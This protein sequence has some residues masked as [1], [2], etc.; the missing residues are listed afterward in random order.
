MEEYIKN[1]FDK[2][3][4]YEMA[5]N[6][7]ISYNKVDWLC[8]KLGLKHYKSVKYTDSEIEFIKNNYPKYGSKYC[9]NKLGRSENALN[10]K[11]KKMGLSIKWKYTY[12]NQQ[13]YLV[14]CKNRNS[15]YAIHRKVMEEKLGRRLTSDEIVHHIDGN[16]L[17]NN[18][19][20]LELTTRSEHIKKHRKDLI[21]GQYKI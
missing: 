15:K 14:N 18:P 21:K 1:N 4:K 11:I 13:G 5:K 2:L 12:I 10:K 19:D 17:N 9:A 3:T 6:L 7:G 16:K 8:R 20:N